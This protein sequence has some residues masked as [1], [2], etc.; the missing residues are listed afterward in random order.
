VPEFDLLVLGDCNPDL[1]VTGD[2]E[3]AYG[4]VE[5]I[6]EAN[7]TIGGSGAIVA[8]GAAR[9]GL[10]TALIGVVGD[11]LF[12]RFML[13]CLADKGV[14]VG[15]CIT[16]STRSTGLSI[17]LAR[18]KDRAILTAPGAINS[19][20]GNDVD[21]DLLRG[22]RHVHVS[23]Y[24]LQ[25]ELQRDL[26]GIFDEAHDAGA[27]TS[28]DPNW[29]PSSRWDGDLLALLDHTDCF[30][31]N[32]AE[33]CRITGAPSVEAAAAALAQATSV[34]AVKEGA[35]G[36][37]AR[38]GDDVVRAPA[39]R[40]DIVD[41]V[42]A[43]DSFVAGFLAGRLRG[44]SLERCLAVACACGSLSARVPGGTDGQPTMEEAADALF[45]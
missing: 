38:Y 32:E 35:K 43:G 22:S 33:A 28:V 21:R 8:C 20:T 31:P 23:S 15:R 45:G 42:G 13:E 27:S 10:R 5:Q 34:V 18:A 2:V 14:H 44:W 36:G 12:G 1:I 6:V 9:L 26:V 29:D 40:V 11:D 39:L 25:S 37:L 3:P 24:Y 17:I 19:L 41:T 30:F 4:Q 7:L 16:T